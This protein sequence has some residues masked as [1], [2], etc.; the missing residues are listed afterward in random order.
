MFEHVRKNRDRK[1]K[2]DVGNYSIETGPLKTGT[3]YLLMQ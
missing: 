2:S 3:S 1:Q